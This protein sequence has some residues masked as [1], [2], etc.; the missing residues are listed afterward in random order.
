VI[1]LGVVIIG[2]NEGER[3]LRCLASLG[4]A[5]ALAV[6]VDSGSTDGSVAAAR[7]AG[8]DVLELDPARPFSAARARNEGFRRLVERSPGLAWVQFVDGDCELAAGWLEA[9]SGE[10]ARAADVGIVCGRLR[11][12]H[13]EASRYNRLCDIEWDT[14]E[15]DVAACGGIFLARAAAF[16]EAGG[17]DETVVAGEE[18]ELCLRL[19]RKGWRVRRVGAEMALH[20]AAMLR[21]AQWWSRSVRAGHAYAQGAALHARGRE[22]FCLRENLSIALWAGL[23]PLA[24][25][26]LAPPTQGA[27]LLLLAAYP[28]QVARIARRHAGWSRPRG[29]AWLYAA[30][31]VLGK[32]P[33]HL[34]QWRYLRSHLRGRAPA[35]IEHKRPASG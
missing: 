13:P 24:A 26:A 6:Y 30:F 1:R 8:C 28:L 10:L 4:G 20:D 11:E 34:G 14:P 21:F 25:L 33:Q 17:F 27:S 35:L 15:G 12:R 7:R 9:G 16:A 18:P 23:W 19:R 32:W 5:A 22:R 29:D 3:L 31:C 2:R